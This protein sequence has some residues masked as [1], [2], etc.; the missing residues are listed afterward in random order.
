MTAST[1]NGEQTATIDTEHTLQTVTSAGSYIL[2]VD[3]NNMALGDKLTLRA[4]VKV[5]SVGTTR[6]AY[7]ASY[8]HAQGEPV[9]ISI[10]IASTNEVVFTLEQTDG[11][12]RAFPWEVIQ[13]DA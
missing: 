5:R 10:P 2:L 4:K 12:C 7:E 1:A 9:K 11:T 8:V 6:L 13:L 3:T